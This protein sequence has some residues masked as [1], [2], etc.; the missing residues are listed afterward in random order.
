MEK[1]PS[2]PKEPSIF[3]VFKGELPAVKEMT[4][5]EP[6][7]KRLLLPVAIAAGIVFEVFGAAKQSKAEK[8]FIAAIKAK[9]DIEE[10]KIRARGCTTDV[11]NIYQSQISVMQVRGKDYAFTLEFD[12]NTKEPTLTPGTYISESMP[13]QPCPLNP[14]DL[15]K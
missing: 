6:L 15:L 9:Y 14:L 4:K 8:K 12:K 2:D 5:S 11:K 3:E 13:Y 7:Y 1:I 10:V